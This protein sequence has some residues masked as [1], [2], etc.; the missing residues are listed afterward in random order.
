ISLIEEGKVSIGTLFAYLLDTNREKKILLEKVEK[1]LGL[2]VFNIKAKTINRQSRKN[3]DE[4]IAPPVEDWLMAF[5]D[6]EF[7]ITDSFHGCIFSIIFNKPFLAIGNE[8]RGLARFKSLLSI[9]GLERRLIS[10]IKDLTDEKIVESIDWNRVNSLIEKE[11]QKSLN[12]L[13]TNLFQGYSD[14]RPFSSPNQE[15]CSS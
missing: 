7:I 1:K 9:S 4:C 13:K 2:K 5:R 6:A 12:F 14:K 10:H 15:A 3:I 8:Q 11:R